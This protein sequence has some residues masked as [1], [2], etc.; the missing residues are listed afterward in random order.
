MPSTTP[1]FGFEYPLSSDNLSDGAQSIQDFATTADT[2]FAD[3]LG[4]TTGQYLAKTTNTNMDFTWT[5]LPSIPLQFP[6]PGSGYYTSNRQFTVHTDLDVEV[7]GANEGACLPVYFSQ[8]TTLDRI[9]IECTV[10]QAATTVRLGIYDDDGTA[11]APGTLILDAG[12]VSTATIGVKEITISQQVSGLVYLVYYNAA[13]NVEF[14]CTR[15]GTA[16]T[17]GM[18]ILQW[19]SAN[20]EP[21]ATSQPYWRRT[22]TGSLPNPAAAT[23]TSA[24]P[25]RGSI[26]LAVRSA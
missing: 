7:P 26:I 2:S 1:N 18:N 4:G 8:P 3:L 19:Q 17:N 20:T 10:A 24:N 13:L 14:R 11:G 15:R 5:T 16:G 6:I 12:T 22:G 23:L 25:Q 9:A 21:F